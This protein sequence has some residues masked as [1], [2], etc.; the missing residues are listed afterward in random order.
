VSFHQ[1]SSSVNRSLTGIVDGCP[2]PLC[3][4]GPQRPGDIVAYSRV[5]STTGALV[6]LLGLMAI[7]ALTH[8]LVTSFRRR[9]RDVALLKT[10]GFVGRQVSSTARWQGLALSGAAL[11]VGIPLGL[12]LGR[13]FW[14]LFADA[15]GVA[16]DSSLPVGPVLLAIPV[17]LV[18]AALVATIPARLARRTRPAVVLRAL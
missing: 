14:T 8:S 6:V 13:V 16:S 4:S 9:R 15:I 1:L 3:V 2:S 18:V 7:A 17:T 5:R 11:L 10:L 12:V